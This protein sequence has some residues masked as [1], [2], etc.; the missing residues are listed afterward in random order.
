MYVGFGTTTTDSTGAHPRPSLCRSNK[1]GRNKT[2]SIY[3]YIYTHTQFHSYFLTS[4][5]FH[6]FCI[7]SRFY[8]GYIS[9]SIFGLSF[10]CNY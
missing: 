4:V 8:I 7:I 9:K 5:S 10:T 6:F 3:I 2:E 1:V